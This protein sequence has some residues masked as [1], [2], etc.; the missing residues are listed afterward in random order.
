MFRPSSDKLARKALL[1]I[2][3]ASAA[4][5]IRAARPVSL[6]FAFGRAGGHALVQIGF[7]SFRLAFDSGQACPNP[8]SCARGM[9]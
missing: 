9:L 3:L 5:G 2:A 7:A 4:L 8:D 6:D 1:L